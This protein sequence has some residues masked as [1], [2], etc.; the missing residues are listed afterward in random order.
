[1]KFKTKTSPFYNSTSNINGVMLQVLYALMP[2]TI[3]MCVFFGWGILFNIVLAIVFALALEAIALKIR[4]RPVMPF[5]SDLSATTAAWLFALTL[6]PLVPWWIVFVGIFFV[7][8]VAKHLY[9]GIGYNPFNPAMV[10]YAVLIVSF[11]F[12][13]SQWINPNNELF[14]FSE[15][16]SFVFGSEKP[17]WDAITAAT[18][19]DEI[20]TGFRAGAE[21]LVVR[22]PNGMPLPQ[23]HLLM[24]SKR[25]FVP[26]QSIQ[27][28]RRNLPICKMLAKT[29]GCGAVSLSLWVVHGCYIKRSFIGRSLLHYWGL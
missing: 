10:G 28:S 16:F 7:I 18:P 24:R 6:P 12:E 14:S 19:L 25:D 9:G 11:P 4:N 27:L 17:E 26:V 29:L 20:K 5:L 13:M 22:N 23:P 1:M 15:S 21:Y 8:I 2:G 3:V